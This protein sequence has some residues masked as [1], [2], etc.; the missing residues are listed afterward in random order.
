[1]DLGEVEV[2]VI[3]LSFF[4]FCFEFV[5]FL[6]GCVLVIEVYF[7]LFREFFF[8]KGF[9]IEFFVFFGRRGEVERVLREYFEFGGFL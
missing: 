7:F 4:F 3:G 2:I 8:F 9:F 1:M 5:I 6:I